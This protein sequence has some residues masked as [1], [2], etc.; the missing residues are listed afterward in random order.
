MKRK[1]LWN[2]K[3]RLVIVE[4]N[5]IGILSYTPIWITPCNLP[6]KKRLVPRS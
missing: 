6:P 1:S 2:K 5:E 4:S 3:T